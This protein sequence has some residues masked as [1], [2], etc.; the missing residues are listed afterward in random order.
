LSPNA[1]DCKARDEAKGGALGEERND[2]GAALG[3][4][5]KGRGSFGRIAALLIACL[6]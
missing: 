1:D 5:P 3:D 6:V 2:A 4:N